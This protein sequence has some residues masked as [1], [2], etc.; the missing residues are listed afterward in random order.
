M[1]ISDSFRIFAATRQGTH[2][3]E[4]P[5]AFFVFYFEK[6]KMF[7]TEQIKAMAAAGNM[8]AF[9]NEW[10]WRKLSAEIIKN[11]HNECEMCRR[12]GK[13]TPATLTHHVTPLR[14]AP[15]LAYERSNLMPLCHDCH[16]MIH[17]RGAYAD[18][19]GYRNTEKW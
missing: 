12:R 13:Y 2:R 7:T 11:G 1:S 10:S 14:Q 17:E 15:E 16:D 18:R 6:A 19:G 5:G 4:T 8:S 9:Y 3:E